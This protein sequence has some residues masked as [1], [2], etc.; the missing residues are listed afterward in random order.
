MLE[1]AYLQTPVNVL[2]GQPQ[3]PCSSL[4]PSDSGDLLAMVSIAHPKKRRACS[5]RSCL[6]AQRFPSHHS[7]SDPS[8]CWA[9]TS[10]RAA[11]QIRKQCMKKEWGQTASWCPR[12]LI[13]RRWVVIRNTSYLSTSI[14]ASKSS[15]ELFWGRNYTTRV[16][17]KLLPIFFLKYSNKY[18][19]PK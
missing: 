15:Q 6:K 11:L 5:S 7:E 16:L 2:L 14:C 10:Q 18:L 12:A 1:W 3:L 17:L 9:F 19:H 4:A 13:Q 8:H